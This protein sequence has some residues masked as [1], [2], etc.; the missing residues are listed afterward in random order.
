MLGVDPQRVLAIGD[1]DNDIPLLEAVGF[2]VAMGESSPGLRA[3]AD[4][5][6][7]PIEGDGA[8]VALEQW[9]LGDA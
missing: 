9:V 1:N 7:P 6:A 5:I 4:W 2:G 3:V 8:A